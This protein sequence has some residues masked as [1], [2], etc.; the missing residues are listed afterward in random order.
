MCL[1]RPRAVHSCKHNRFDTGDNGGD[2]YQNVFWQN[3]KG[4]MIKG[5]M[6]EGNRVVH[7]TGF[8]NHAFDI[9]IPNKEYG[10]PSTDPNKQYSNKSKVYNNA[11]DDWRESRNPKCEEPLCSPPCQAGRNSVGQCGRPAAHEMLRDVRVFDFRPQ[12]GSRL[13]GAASGSF[14]QFAPGG[15][16][17]IG[18]YQA[19]SNHY[20]AQLCQCLV[21]AIL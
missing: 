13:V 5:G 6:S 15:E 9:F 10:E 12:P 3:G 2:V 8:K 19:V 20:I 21:L 17:T 7:N 18:A 14:S 11:A 1:C 16:K 4:F